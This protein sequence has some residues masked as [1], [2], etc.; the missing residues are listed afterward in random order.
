MPV[1][2]DIPKQTQTPL[3]SGANSPQQ[4][5]LM[6]IDN[7]NQKQAAMNSLGGK[8]IKRGGKRIKRGGGTI[9]IPPTNTSSY[10]LNNDV[11]NV[12]TS[13]IKSQVNAEYDNGAFKGGKTKRRRTRRKNNKKTKH[14]RR[15]RSCRH[16]RH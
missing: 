4:S 7:M 5:A 10:N 9:E 14:T 12:M 6:K 2:L 11:K 3:E 8:R 15:R 1:A 13:N 16:R